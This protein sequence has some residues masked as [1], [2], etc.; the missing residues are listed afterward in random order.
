MLTPKVERFPLHAAS[1]FGRIAAGH[2]PSPQTASALQCSSHTMSS[3]FFAT[4]PSG[5]SPGNR[6]SRNPRFAPAHMHP[7]H[8]S[9]LEACCTGTEFARTSSLAKPRLNCLA[10]ALAQVPAL[11]LSSTLSQW[12]SG[13]GVRTTTVLCL[14]PAA[15]SWDEPRRP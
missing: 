7:A 4:K 8:C 14:G 9:P 10:A 3:A 1:G 12:L 5:R 2:R 6:S 11:A 15:A 13:K